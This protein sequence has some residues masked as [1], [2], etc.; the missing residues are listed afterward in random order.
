MD[1]W[2]Q[3]VNAAG[4]ILNV[5]WLHFMFSDECP[6]WKALGHESGEV[7]RKLG[8]RFGVILGSRQVGVG[9]DRGE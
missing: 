5:L 6:D 7:V 9:I 1:C 3:A 8:L 4:C 2:D